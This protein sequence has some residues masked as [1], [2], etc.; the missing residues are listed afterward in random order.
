MIQAARNAHHFASLQIM[1]AQQRSFTGGQRAIDRPIDQ[2]FTDRAGVKTCAINVANLA[3]HNGRHIDERRTK[4]R[5]LTTKNLT[6][7]Q[8]DIRC[9]HQAAERKILQLTTARL[10]ILADAD[11]R[12][13]IETDSLMTTLFAHNAFN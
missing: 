10:P 9:H 11:Q 3:H 7:F 1:Y 13:Q 4:N 6:D 12:R 5:K 2:D 8:R